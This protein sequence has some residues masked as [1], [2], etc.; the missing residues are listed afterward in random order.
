LQERGRQDLAEVVSAVA[1]LADITCLLQ[2]VPRGLGDA[3]LRAEAYVQGEPFAVLLPDEILI[4]P[5][6][7]LRQLLARHQGRPGLALAVCDVPED[8]VSRYG[9]IDAREHEPG[10]WEVRGV[11]EKPPLDKAPSRLAISGRYVLTADIFPAL[12]ATP[13]GA[14][15][16]LQLTD[17]VATLLGHVPIW[18]YQLEGDRFDV[19]SLAGYLKA[20]IFLAR[21]QPELWQELRAFIQ[22]LG[23]GG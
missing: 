6:P 22:N 13:P 17:A 2:E 19:G 20:I 12:R 18:A 1:E 8:Q 3:I 23:G 7:G 9:I 11:V 15:G 21:Q 16:E 5:T 4:G 14:G 10:V